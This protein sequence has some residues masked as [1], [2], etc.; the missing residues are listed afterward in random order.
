[1]KRWKRRSFLKMG[2]GAMVSLFLPRAHGATGSTDGIIIGAGIAGLA[3]G[4]ELR[5]RGWGVTI[6]E[7]RERVGG[8]VWSRAGL[9]VQLTERR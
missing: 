6:L 1:M 8:R 3:A 7:A 9:Q 5:K 4:D 2:G